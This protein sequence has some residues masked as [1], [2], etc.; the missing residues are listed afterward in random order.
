MGAGGNTLHPVMAEVS[1]HGLTDLEQP[2][3]Q[4]GPMEQCRN[5]NEHCAPSTEAGACLVFPNKS[6]A[7]GRLRPIRVLCTPGS[8]WPN[9]KV[10]RSP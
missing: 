4:Q 10:T 8:S 3:E 2:Q 1:P 9:P 7:E 5:M 6:I